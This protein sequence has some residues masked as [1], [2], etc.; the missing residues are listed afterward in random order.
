VGVVYLKRA[1]RVALQMARQ[2]IIK[3]LNG[4]GNQVGVY[5]AGACGCGQY[6]RLGSGDAAGPAYAVAA[7]LKTGRRVGSSGMVGIRAGNH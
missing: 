4:M 6:R 2:T 3:A 7:C 5:A 1:A